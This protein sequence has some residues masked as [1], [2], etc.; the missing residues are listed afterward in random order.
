MKKFP[1]LLWAASQRRLVQYELAAAVQMT[2][3]RFSRCLSGRA[4][5]S[6]NERVGLEA[7]LGYPAAWLF[8]D[9]TPPKSAE[10]RSG[11]AEVRRKH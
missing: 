10:K 3:T 4:K 6:D 7:L 11:E 9:L 5:F 2:E 8:Q 1:K